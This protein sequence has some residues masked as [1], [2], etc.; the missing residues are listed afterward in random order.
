[1]IFFE[2]SNKTIAN[3]RKIKFSYHNLIVK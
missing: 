1:M 3:V 2:L